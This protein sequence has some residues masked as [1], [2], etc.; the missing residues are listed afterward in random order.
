MRLTKRPGEQA[1]LWKK[2]KDVALTDVGVLVRG[3]DEGSLEKIEE[4]LLGA[5][6]GV[7]ATLRLVDVVETQSRG[8]KI[9]TEQ[10]FQ[11]VVQREIVKI[12][13]EGDATTSLTF[14]A[15]PPTVI[16]MVGVN[17]VG[18]TTTIGKLAHRFKGEGRSVLL[19]AGDTFRAGAIDQLRLWSERAAVG[20][21]GAQPGADPASV[22]FDAI[23]AAYARKADVVIIETAGRLHTQGDLMTELAKI[24]RVIDRRLPGAPH[25]T[26][27]VLDATV[28]QNAVSQAR[29][30]RQALP[31]TGLALAKLD[32]T[33]RGGIV[34]ALK[35]EFDLPVKLVGTGEGVDAL[36]SFDAEQFARDVL[37]G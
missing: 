18:K 3:L 19:A 6:F 36:T 32:S 5:D 28:G 12:L 14:A 25:E 34:V 30:F 9:K 29:M 10:Q 24:E 21:V 16:L 23:D 35:H 37:T 26:L 2:I 11:D 17:G 13:G 1:S 15:E 22:A 20:F 27:L 8:G 33:A 31:L 7:P 4:T